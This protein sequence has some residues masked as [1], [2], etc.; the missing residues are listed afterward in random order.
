MH[1]AF[2]VL[3][4]IYLMDR[5]YTNT[6]IRTFTLFVMR[7][8]GRG[9]QERLYDSKERKV[10]RSFPSPDP[11]RLPAG[12]VCEGGQSIYNKRRV[13]MVFQVKGTFHVE[14]PLCNGES[15]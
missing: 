14:A 9:R 11:G 13:E 4:H 6:H 2:S 3:V 5:P 7:A 15:G 10:I 8:N 1:A 12:Y